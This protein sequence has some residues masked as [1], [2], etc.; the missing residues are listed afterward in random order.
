MDKSPYRAIEQK[1]RP[2]RSFDHILCEYTKKI[3]ED[4]AKGAILCIFVFNRHLSNDDLMKKIILIIAVLALGA[5]SASAEGT[6]EETATPAQPKA[7]GVK[8]GWG[9]DISY[10]QYMGDN[11]LE[12]NLGL[13]NFNSLDFATFYNFTI[14]RPEW[15]DVGRWGMYFGP[16][17]SLG[18]KLFGKTHFF[19][20][21]A[22]CMLGVE[23]T[24]DI[25]LQL[26]FDV[27]PQMGV[28][29][30]HGFYWTVTPSFG[31]RYS[32]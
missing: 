9:T 16:G 29:F 4:I 1:T 10:Q 22:A 5:A 3:A 21:S 11:F 13:D 17:C 28:G 25:P 15:T 27:K 30:G 24:F 26:S 12:V 31:V 18:M 20:I 6:T 23:Y 2:I 32:F 8:V 19:H 7:I 14:A